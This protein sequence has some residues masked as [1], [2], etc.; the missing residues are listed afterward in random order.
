MRSEFSVTQILN[1]WFYYVGLVPSCP[2]EEIF[3][4]K[5]LEL[6]F[7]ESSGSDGSLYVKE[8]LALRHSA[9]QELMKF[10]EDT[11]EAQRAKAECISQVLN[12]K[13]SAEGRGYLPHKNN[14]CSQITS[15]L[16][17]RQ[18]YSFVYLSYVFILLYK[19][20][21]RCQDSKLY[22]KIIKIFLKAQPIHFKYLY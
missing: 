3:L 20:Y 18:L 12:G 16:A 8:A 19:A 1:S 22:M 2:A 13:P 21:I 9:T 5:L 7:S 4:Y 14:Y 17:L 15:V 11:I 6:D 10:L